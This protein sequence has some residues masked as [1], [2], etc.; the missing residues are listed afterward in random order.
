MDDAY[1]HYEIILIVTLY[2][3]NIIYI[4]IIVNACLLCA[5]LIWLAG[6]VVCRRT[7][8]RGLP[9]PTAPLAPRPTHRSH[10]PI[11]L[12]VMI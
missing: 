4:I 12:I 11:D 10:P 1:T 7:G 5:R 8:R 9:R 6:W 2:F 3:A